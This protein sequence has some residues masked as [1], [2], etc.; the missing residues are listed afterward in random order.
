[1]PTYPG[2]VAA[3]S[4]RDGWRV[5]AIDLGGTSWYRVWWHGTLY[6][7]QIGRRRGLVRT[8]AEVAE[9]LGDSYL[10]LENDVA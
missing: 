4:T 1:M 8:V 2:R 6:G 10:L 9:L 7:G 5:E 3:M